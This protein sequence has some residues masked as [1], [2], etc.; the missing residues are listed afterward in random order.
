MA[1]SRH[2]WGAPPYSGPRDGHAKRELFIHHEAGPVRKPANA[3]SEHGVMREI[4]NF[5]IH[6]RGWADIAYSYVLFPSGR[7]YTGRGFH[8]LPAAQLNHN[9]GT[10]A[11][12]LAGN[13]ETQHLTDSQKRRLIEACNNLAK[14]GVRTVGGHREAP[15]Q[16]TACPGSHVMPFLNTL[17]DKSRLSRYHR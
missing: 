9:S 1:R 3:T 2:E 7:L 16:S 8:G 14:L 10:I 12:C 17:A 15:G 4:R 6:T 13:Y 11:I 5:H